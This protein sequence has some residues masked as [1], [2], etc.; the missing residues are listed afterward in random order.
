MGRRPRNDELITFF[1]C[2]RSGVDRPAR[3][4]PPVVLH[5]ILMHSIKRIEAG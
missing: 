5:Q 2:V 1:V 4:N 3:I